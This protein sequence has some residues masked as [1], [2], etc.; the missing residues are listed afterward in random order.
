MKPT[1]KKYAKGG[2]VLKMA[3]GGL[4]SPDMRSSVLS[5]QPSAP[6]PVQGQ[7]PSQ[8]SMSQQ[9]TGA[10]P[11][12]QIG[13]AVSAQKAMDAFRAASP[14]MPVQGQP[15]SQSSMSQRTTGANPVGA[16]PVD[17]VTAQKAMDAFRAASPNMRSRGQSMQPPRLAPRNSKLGGDVRGGSD[18]PPRL[19]PR[20]SK[21]GGDVR[22]GSFKA[23]IGTRDPPALG[24]LGGK[25]GM[26]PVRE[27]KKGG[28]VTS[29]VRPRGASGRGV[30]ACKIS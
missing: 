28:M 29:S 11:M 21:L 15:M 17:A 14:N 3:A 25:S 10:K 22:G 4:V 30:K 1:T 16:N 26:P 2:K 5:M 19:A 20:N 24:I 12:T 7:Q 18:R 13:N 23:D 9:M 6:L 27:Y 8:S